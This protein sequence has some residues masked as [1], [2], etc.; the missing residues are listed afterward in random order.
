[1]REK[2]VPE[3]QHHC[4]NT[5]FILVGTKVDLKT[6][7]AEL[8]KL[9]KRKETVVSKEYGERLAKELGAVMYTE[10]SALTVQYQEC[11]R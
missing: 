2:W 6:E 5:P 3:I 4:P 1:M 9:S 11:F 7:P 8:E 10:C